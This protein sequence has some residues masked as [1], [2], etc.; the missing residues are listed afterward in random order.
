[1][2]TLRNILQTSE[3]RNKILF[4]LFV[5]VIYRLGVQIPAPGVSLDAIESLRAQADQT[6]GG[7][8]G[9]LNL[10]SGGGLRQLSLFSLGVLPYITASI[11]IQI[12]TVAIPKLEQWQSQGAVGQRKINQWTRYVA[13]VLAIVQATGIVFM[14]GRNPE[15]F[16]GVDVGLFP[17]WNFGRVVLAVTCMVVGTAVVMWL[18]ELIT[19]KGIGNGM[20]LI[21]MA[22]VVSNMPELGFRIHAVRGWLWVVFAFVLLAVLVAGIVFVEQGQRRIPVNFAKRVVGRRQYGGNNTYIPLKVN[23]AG[24][25]PVIFASSLLQLPSF[26]VNVLPTSNDA[27]N[28]NWGDD[29]RNFVQRNLY[30]PDN[31]GYILVFGALIV[32]FAYFY[33]AVAFD[34]SRRADELRKSGGFIP[35]IRPGPQTERHLSKILNR[36]TLPGAVFLAVVALIPS[37]ALARLLSGGGQGRAVGF[38]GVS[39]LIAAGV[40][41]ETMKQINSQL[42]AKNYDGFLK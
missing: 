13:I 36:I 19:Q 2:N 32:G 42:M 39:I 29:V 31:L 17:V 18:G 16:F 30:H 15:A 1:M 27:T 41:L 37:A 8:F 26:I 38:S 12:L 6:T 4:T 20:S 7:I 23:Q 33:N 14:I 5:V 11:I 34:P 25:I 40:S 28:P 22:S 9:Y 10:F 35:G 21:I 24:V 3:L